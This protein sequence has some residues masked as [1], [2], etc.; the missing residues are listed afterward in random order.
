LYVLC[1]IISA[2]LYVVTYV[3]GDILRPGYSTIADS[4]SEL[5]EVNAPNKS[6]LDSMLLVVH[7]LVI[8]FAYGLHWGIDEGNGSKAGP[9]MLAISGIMGIILTLFFP[10]DPGGKPVTVTG[11]LHVIIA[12]LGIGFMTIFAILA[13]SLRFKKSKGWSGFFKYS[14]ITSL[15]T[16]LLA[17]ITCIF[18]E[19]SFSG[20][21]ERLV[22]AAYHQWFIVMGI[23]VMSQSSVKRNENLLL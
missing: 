19:S 17:L 15:I 8:P 6:L 9:I 1:G 4:V 13:F 5:V 21:L 2:L 10:C 20:L 23:A 14:M 22:G 7:A 12:V 18:V 3:T 11:F 16:F